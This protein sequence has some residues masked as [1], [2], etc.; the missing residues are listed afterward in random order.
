MSTLAANKVGLAGLEILA[1]DQAASG[2]G[3]EFVNTGRQFLSVFNG[4][5]G[6]INVTFDAPNTCDHLL[7]ADA[8]H[9][10]VV[11]V[12]SGKHMLIGPFPPKRFN[13]SD[14]K[15]QITYSGVTSLL[16]VLLE[17]EGDTTPR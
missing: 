16:V 2:G 3:D 1:V 13:D 9:D 17:F 15:V 4:N 8:N 6:S 5:G 11:A 12:A 14:G 10:E 7:A